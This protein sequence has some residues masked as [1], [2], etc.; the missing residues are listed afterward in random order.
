MDPEIDA[1]LEELER[2][3]ERLQAEWE[4]QQ[5]RGRHVWSASVGVLV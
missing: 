4:Q 3:E 5:V 2:E 1:K